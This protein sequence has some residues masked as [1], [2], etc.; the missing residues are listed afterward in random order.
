MVLFMLLWSDFRSDLLRFRG[1]EIVLVLLESLRNLVRVGM[2]NQRALLEVLPVDE[3][4]REQHVGVRPVLFL[5]SNFTFPSVTVSVPR[6]P[7]MPQ[8]AG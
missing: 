1:L 7:Q 5:I 6:T 2:R 8:M 3:L 4:A